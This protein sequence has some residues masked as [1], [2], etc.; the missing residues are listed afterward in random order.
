MLNFIIIVSVVILYFLSL[1]NTPE[2]LGVNVFIS[3]GLIIVSTLLYFKWMPLVKNANPCV[4]GNVVNFLKIMAFVVLQLWTIRCATK[5][6]P[7]VGALLL[8]L[9]VYL[10]INALP[11]FID[12][13]DNGISSG[14]RFYLKLFMAIGSAVVYF[15]Y[16]WLKSINFH[17]RPFSDYEIW[18]AV[19][20]LVFVL[21]Y[22]SDRAFSQLFYSIGLIVL[23]CTLS[24]D[25]K[26]VPMADRAADELLC[27]LIFS[28]IVQLVAVYWVSRNYPLLGAFVF[29][30]SLCGW[31]NVAPVEHVDSDPAGAGMASGFRIIV[32]IILSSLFSVVYLLLLKYVKSNV[33]PLICTALLGIYSIYVLRADIGICRSRDAKYEAERQMSKES[34]V[35]MHNKKQKHKSSKSTYYTSRKNNDNSKYINMQ[36][37]CDS[38][39]DLNS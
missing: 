39:V 34:N 4:P 24:F 38:S 19:T 17:D 16:F 2:S 31:M 7:M 25:S 22:M 29:G 14:L 30:L 3:I 37:D 6:T 20:V 21:G 23:V 11:I 8:G 27:K 15:L 35:L 26:W 9:S 32:H 10:W 13:V 18:F 28:I 1:I 36:E 33:V 12:A 5:C